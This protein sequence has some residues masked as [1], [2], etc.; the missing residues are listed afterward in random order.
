MSQHIECGRCPWAIPN[1]P[2]ALDALLRHSAAAHGRR[3]VTVPA[4]GAIPYSI[5]RSSA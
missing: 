4:D 1:G 5:K 2:D 3:P